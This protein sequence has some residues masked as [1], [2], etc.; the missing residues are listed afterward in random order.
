M[1]AVCAFSFTRYGRLY[2]F[3]PGGHAPAVGDKV[4]VPTD[5]GAEVA[6]CVWA[7]QEVPDEIPDL[8]V[9]VGP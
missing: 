9:L 5:A 4:L 6:Q 3:D 8:P 2:Y 1:P 7:P